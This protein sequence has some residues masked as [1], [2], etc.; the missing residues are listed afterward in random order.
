MLKVCPDILVE[1]LQGISPP[2]SPVGELN[3]DGL[4]APTPYQERVAMSDLT[5][6]RS[7]LTVLTFSAMFVVGMAHGH[8]LA[9]DPPG[10][11][12]GPP[13]ICDQPDD[14]EVGNKLSGKAKSLAGTHTIEATKDGVPISA[15]DIHVTN[16]GSGE[17][18]YE[19][20]S[21]AYGVGVE[22]EVTATNI[23]SLSASTITTIIAA[24]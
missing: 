10:T 20:D 14:L 1:H 4:H 8:L 11:G 22:I 17:T 15:E 3:T 9:D 18:T 6:R 21:E 23:Y 13:V 2:F 5:L 7:I 19:I 12:I 16:H 24:K